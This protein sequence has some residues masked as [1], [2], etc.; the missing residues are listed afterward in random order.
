MK[1][2][3]RLFHRHKLS[4]AVDP[5]FRGRFLT[6]W[7]QYAVPA[8]VTAFRSRAALSSATANRPLARRSTVRFPPNIFVRAHRPLDDFGYGVHRGSGSLQ[9]RV[10]PKRRSPLIY[11]I[12]CIHEDFNGRRNNPAALYSSRYP[13]INLARNTCADW[14]DFLRNFR[15][16]TVPWP[17]SRAAP[18]HSNGLYR[19]RATSPSCRPFSARWLG[20]FDLCQPLSSDV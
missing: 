3:S 12:G 1:R 11:N 7:R 8:A 5:G 19:P 4:R 6:N 9:G 16:H 14:E 2:K 15:R 10:A 18:R 13:K 20:L 17:A